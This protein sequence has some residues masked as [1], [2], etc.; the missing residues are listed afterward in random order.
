MTKHTACT[1]FWL[2]ALLLPM[3][4]T[5][6]EPADK[7]SNLEDEASAV[8]TAPVPEGAE[9]FPQYP[10]SQETE[11]TLPLSPAEIAAIIL[12]YPEQCKTCRYRVVSVVGQEVFEREQNPYRFLVWQNVNKE[13]NVL[14]GKIPFR[15]SSWTEVRVFESSDRDTIIIDSRLLEPDRAAKLAD[16]Y[17]RP[18]K[19]AFAMLHS[20]W[21]IVALEPGATG[22]RVSRVHGIVG[23]KGQ[24]ISN[25]VPNSVMRKELTGVMEETLDFVVIDDAP[26]TA[27]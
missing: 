19:P 1:R 23:G 17:E 25:L 2:A 15:S 4:A 26:G 14:V 21:T 13:I 7:T 3:L 6:E 27:E 20:R 24:G 16:V 11:R 12:A 22:E 9:R 18:S 5:A 8:T 10:V